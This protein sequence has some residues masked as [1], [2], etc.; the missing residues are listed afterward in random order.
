[1]YNVAIIISLPTYVYL[2]Y[3]NNGSA[4]TFEY[5]IHTR[6][7]LIVQVLLMMR[8]EHRFSRRLI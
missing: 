8:R 7:F 5:K 6:L 1:M 4:M 3:I 2:S